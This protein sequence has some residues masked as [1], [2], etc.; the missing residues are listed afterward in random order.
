MFKLFDRA[1]LCNT[2]HLK[3]SSAKRKNK[4]RK[5]NRERE[6]ERKKKRKKK[7]EKK[8][9]RKKKERKRVA[10]KKKIK[11]SQPDERGAMQFQAQAGAQGKKLQGRQIDGE[12]R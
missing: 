1:S 12:K 5:R 9:K 4:E 8:G 10:R 11:A 3:I 2:E 7:G 6:R